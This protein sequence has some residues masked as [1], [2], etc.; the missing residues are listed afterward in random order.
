MDVLV[1][2]LT[3]GGDIIARRL[4]EQGHRVTIADIYGLASPEARQS[5]IASDIRVS[6]KPPAEDFDLLVS[7]IH[8]P[9]SYIA[10][11]LFRE[12]K[13]FSDMVGDL[14]GK[15]PFRIEITGVKGKTS[16]CYLLAHILSNDGKNVLLHTSRGRELIRDGI[17][18]VICSQVSIAPTS[19]LAPV[20]NDVD[21]I[22]NEVSLGGSGKADMAIITNLVHDYPIAANTR[23][24]R[25]GK[26]SIISECGI[27][28]IPLDELDIWK[29]Y[30]PINVHFHGGNVILEQYA[31]L[32]APQ[33]ITLLLKKHHRVFLSANFLTTA[34]LQSIEIAS[35]AANLL[36]VPE[37]SIVNS[38]E[39]F[40]GVP[41]RC[42][43]H[44]K[45]DGYLLLEKNPGIS[46][47][48]IEHVLSFLAKHTDG[49]NIAVLITPAT[50]KVCE[51][52]ELDLIKPI[53]DDHHGDLIISAP[54]IDINYDELFQNYP[55][56]AHFQKEAYQ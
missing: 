20:E 32:G 38:I 26:S 19:L 40:S 10:P 8:C 2:D 28:L 14:I 44:R 13:F 50:K 1:L 43:I 27:N 39:T 46:H 17:S 25:E 22:V 30:N 9:D 12:R 52:M 37:K 4:K 5:L 23:L 48:S 3:H 49:A 36:G 56:V 53:V 45:N 29:K 41:G 6:D 47:L 55:I 16:T 11:A 33:E 51:K 35:T 15:T 54:G 21:Y 31:P 18:S 34:F 7:P 42:E 24:A